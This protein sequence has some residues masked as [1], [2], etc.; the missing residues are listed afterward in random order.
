MTASAFDVTV[1]QIPRVSKGDRWVGGVAAAIA[2][3]VGVQPLVIRASFIVLGAAG[4]WGLV[5]YAVSWIALSM[6]GSSAIDYVPVAKG[7]T[8]FHRHAGVAMIVIGSLALFLSLTSAVFS[9]IVWPVGFVTLGALIS[10]TRGR[11]QSGGLAEVARVVAGLI[12]ALGGLLAF[13]AVN[14]SAADTLV[15]LALALSVVV[16]IGI[17]AAPTLIRMAQDLDSER[18]DRARVDERARISAHL[19]DSVLQTLSLIQR[20]VDDPVKT[21]HLARQ[22]ERDL[23]N[24]L[25]GPTPVTADGIRL[26]SAL[27]EA[28]SAVEESHGVRIDVVGVGDIEYPGQTLEPLIAAAKEAMT[29]AA[30]HSGSIEISVYSERTGDTVEVFVRDTGVGFDPDDVASD[31]HGLSES[32]IG[33][34][35]RAGGSAT[36]RTD[37]GDGTEVELS[38]PLEG[39]TSS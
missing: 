36:V 21:T 37:L 32:I 30:K 20:H 14:L 9:T 1:W 28:A 4:G 26:T 7:R 13:T 31:R 34:M 17:V 2:H 22:Q 38:L 23:R 10:W 19:H 24:W 15:A 12:V 6:A 16:G 8:P 11:D 18:T 35:E 25:Y 5:L 3:E 39:E 29:N 33:R 27:E